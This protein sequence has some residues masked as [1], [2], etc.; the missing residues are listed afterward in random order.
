M[1]LWPAPKTGSVGSP[2]NMVAPG[3]HLAHPPLRLA[4]AIAIQTQCWSPNVYLEYPFAH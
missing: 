4:L 3:D 1:Q 2:L